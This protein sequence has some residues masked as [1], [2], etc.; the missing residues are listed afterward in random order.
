MSVSIPLEKTKKVKKVIPP[1][2]GREVSAY[3][4]ILN[5]EEIQV[6]NVPYYI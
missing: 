1:P 5:K 3:D 6:E 4:I 2:N